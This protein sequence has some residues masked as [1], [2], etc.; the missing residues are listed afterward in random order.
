MAYEAE[1]SEV[2]TLKISENGTAVVDAKT[3]V[4]RPVPEIMPK[5]SSIPDKTAKLAK[6]R[7][8]R[9]VVLSTVVVAVLFT[10]W[11]LASP[12][13]VAMTKPQLATITETITSSG[14]VGGTTETNVGAQTAGI[15]SRLYVIEGSQVV[16]GQQLALI[17]NDV[18]RAQIDQ[19]RAALETARTQLQQASRG[20]LPSDID[21][22]SEQV[23]QAQAQVEQQDSAITQAERSVLQAQALLSQFQAERDFAK[24]EL[25]RSTSLVEGGII[26]RSEYDKSVTTFRIAEKKVSAQQQA[27]AFAESV[28]RSARS[29]LKSSQA[30]LRTQQA[31]L[32]TIQSGARPED[33]AFAR[34]RIAESE[35]ALRVAEKQAANAVVIAPYA[36]TVTKINTEESQTVGSSGVVT[37]V[38]EQ[39][40][41]RVDVDESNLSALAVGQTALISSGAF[42]DTGFEAIV[43]EIAAAVNETRGTIEVKVVPVS[44]PE[45]LR[46]GQTVDVNIVTGKNVARLLVPQEALVRSG[47]DTVVF[48]ITDGKIAHK[49]V[50]TRPPTKDGVPVINGLTADDLFVANA[51]AVTLGDSVEAE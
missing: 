20:A 5:T 46:P 15:V 28:V 40:E 6:K 14:R 30:N 32:R 27:I 38:S 41:V 17:K 1:G 7:I 11:Y 34:K 44:S 39:L 25:D 49:I 31:R 19:A 36:G 48:I 22:L 33:I 16:T 18:A 13:K 12:T 24:K 10:V 47:D 21:A 45:W 51:S 9:F 43:S 2:E 50:V 4:A 23:R 42:S 29:G 3:V 8:V 37:L 35:N 26:S